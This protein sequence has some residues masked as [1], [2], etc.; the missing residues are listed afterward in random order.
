M[1][2]DVPPFLPRSNRS[3]TRCWI[4]WRIQ[5]AGE[6]RTVL[7]G[8]GRSARFPSLRNKAEI[9]GGIGAVCGLATAPCVDVHARPPARPSLRNHRPARL[10]DRCARPASS[11]PEAL[12]G[13]SSCHLHDS[14]LARLELL[15]E[16]SAPVRRGSSRGG[17]VRPRLSRG[18][19]P[20][21]WI[22]AIAACGMGPDRAGLPLRA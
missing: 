10:K 9:A 21:L 12:R 14:E 3:A 11:R 6:P 2:R 1:M 5:S 19:A 17:P 13:T 20:K 18:D 22:D 4:G 8:R 7:A 16:P 15:H